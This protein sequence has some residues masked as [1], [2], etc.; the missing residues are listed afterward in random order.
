MRTHVMDTKVGV[1]YIEVSLITC[2]VTS[3]K[4]REISFPCPGSLCPCW[5]TLI[6]P[7][8]LPPCPSCSVNNATKTLL[9]DLTPSVSRKHRLMSLCR[10]LSTIHRLRTDWYLSCTTTSIY[11]NGTTPKSVNDGK[12]TCMCV[13]ILSLQCSVKE[14]V[15]DTYRTTT[16]ATKATITRTK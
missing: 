9:Y 4:S 12:H 11:I 6:L 7:D 10:W 16:T 2:R 13:K 14:P 5:T 15:F 1:L 8:L 3:H